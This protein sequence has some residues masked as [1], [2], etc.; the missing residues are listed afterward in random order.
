MEREIT[1]CRILNLATKLK[2]V[3][4]DSEASIQL[5][6]E[7]LKIHKNLNSIKNINYDKEFVYN[8]MIKLQEDIDS[9]KKPI[10]Y[11]PDTNLPIK[12]LNFNKDHYL[13]VKTNALCFCCLKSKHFSMFENLNET[14]W[15]TSYFQEGLVCKTCN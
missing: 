2:N 12:V 8:E 15:P 7:I 13:P 10:I 3:A 9:L 11:C 4:I 6:T 5:K 1:S 14:N